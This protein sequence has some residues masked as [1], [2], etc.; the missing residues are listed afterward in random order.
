MER[1][2]FEV[3]KVEEDWMNHVVFLISA[4]AEWQEVVKMFQHPLK[5]SPYGNWFQFEKRVDDGSFLCTYFHGGWGKIAAAGSAQYIVDIFQPDLVV[6]LGTCGGFEGRTKRGDII[7]V[8]E[9][10]VY[11]IY[12]QM[13][14]QNEARKYFSTNIDITWLGENFPCEVIINK[15]LS[16]DRDICCEDIE[17]LVEDYDGIVGDWESGA[18]AY[19]LSKNKIRFLIL[20]GVSDIISK[21]CGEAY[22]N[23][24]LFC[25]RTREIMEKLINLF[26]DWIIGKT[27]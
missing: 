5:P 17:S 22:G 8:N 11:D 1:K 21:E 20:R 24:E 14:D 10:I 15:M 27:L 4:D 25:E 12:E 9:T 13:T 3:Y 26:P 2:I 6:N 7:L 19:V 23:Y 18:I 16:A